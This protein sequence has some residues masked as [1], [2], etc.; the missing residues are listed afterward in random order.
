MPLALSRKV[1]ES[2]LIGPDIRVEVGVCV[3]GKARLLITAP[4]DIKILREEIAERGEDASA[5][6][7]ARSASVS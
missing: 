5:V 2:I 4:A 7:A 3:K 1:G 6:S